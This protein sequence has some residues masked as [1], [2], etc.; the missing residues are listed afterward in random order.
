[1]RSFSG[2]W[3]SATA[4]TSTRKRHLTTNK[5]SG[6]GDDDFVPEEVPP[7]DHSNP[8]ENDDSVGD[9]TSDDDD[10][11]NEDSHDPLGPP[12]STNASVTQTTSLPLGDMNLMVLTDVHSWIGGHQRHERNMNADYGDVL[13]L[14][15]R[16]KDEIRRK[17]KRDFFMVMNGDFMDGTGLSTT[18]PE[19]LTPLLATMPFAIINL[20]NHEL[21]HEETVAWIKSEFIPHWRGH[22]LTS[23]TLW[24]PTKQ[25]LGSRYVFLEGSHSTLL[26]FGFLYNFQGNAKNTIVEN[27]QDV[28]QQAWFLSVLARTDAYDAILVMA[29]VSL[30][31][32][33][34]CCIGE[35]TGLLCRENI[36]ALQ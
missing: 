24:R 31:F 20:G 23:N 11:D 34:S 16:L 12:F 10:D 27:V 36:C 6:D 2:P 4:L 15:Q 21:Y 13:S 14:Y 22:Y 7:E 32:C 26:A 17:Y 18:P 25:P 9:S 5:L 35:M 3:A 1:M 19:Y 30:S 29:H 33:L 28:V 8:A